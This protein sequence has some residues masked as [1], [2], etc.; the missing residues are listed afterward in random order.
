MQLVITA[1]PDDRTEVS[2]TASLHPTDQTAADE[3]SMSV[4]LFHCLVVV[5]HWLTQLAGIL[6]WCWMS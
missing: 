2:L 4:C 1:F 6:S 5:K 3:Q